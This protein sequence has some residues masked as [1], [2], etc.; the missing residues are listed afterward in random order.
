MVFELTQL[1]GAGCFGKQQ[2]ILGGG[3]LPGI[4]AGAQGNYVGR[5]IG[6]SDILVVDMPKLGQGGYYVKE[7]KVICW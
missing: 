4:Y 5:D 7:I 6:S 3:G 2:P 1:G